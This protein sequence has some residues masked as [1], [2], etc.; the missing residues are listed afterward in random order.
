MLEKIIA[1][2][3]E[4]GLKI[5]GKPLMWLMSK[6]NRLRLRGC[7]IEVV[8]FII[9]RND[10]SILLGQS[11]YH[12]MWMP[13]Q[14]GVNMNEGFKDALDRCLRVECGL[15]LPTDPVARDRL[16]HLRSIKYLGTLELPSER[17][18]ERLVA[19]DAVGTPVE[20][21]TLKC[22]AYWKAVLL[23]TSSADLNP[24]PDGTELVALRWFPLDEA[25][26]SIWDTNHI[27]KAEMLIQGLIE[28]KRDLM[29]ARKRRRRA[30]MH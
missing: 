6:P 24:Q 13:P 1:W 10:D 29:G 11:P 22:K 2:G 19:E 27:G 30:R 23:V 26:Q 25:R 15:D 17:Q 16:L 4:W 8:A 9:S 5:V 18:G 7:R 28:V 14:E 3:L 20:H 12:N 21:V